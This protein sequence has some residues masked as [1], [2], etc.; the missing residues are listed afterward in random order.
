MTSNNTNDDLTVKNIEKW[1]F[2]LINKMM[3][4]SNVESILKIFV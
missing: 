1:Q 4:F 2:L 3:C